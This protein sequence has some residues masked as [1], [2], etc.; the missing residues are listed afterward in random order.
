[1]RATFTL[2]PHLCAPRHSAPQ[3]N[4][5]AN[6]GQNWFTHIM[7]RLQL[8][9]EQN[10]NS[11]KTLVWWH[12]RCSIFLSLNDQNRCLLHESFTDGADNVLWDSIC[13]VHRYLMIHIQFTILHLRSIVWKILWSECKLFLCT[14]FECNTHTADASYILLLAAS[15]R[16]RVIFNL[17]LIPRRSR[18]CYN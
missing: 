17:K 18:V 6:L 2:S 9:P 1:M 3:N 7:W 16:L 13:S 14:Q 11:Y 12:S 4:I 8:S 5:L 15:Y 10:F